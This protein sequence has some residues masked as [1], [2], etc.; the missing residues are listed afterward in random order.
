MFLSRSLGLVFEVI[1]NSR[2]HSFAL[3][4]H[5]SL[6]RLCSYRTDCA[7]SSACAHTVSLKAMRE[8]AGE[9]EWERRGGRSGSG[10]P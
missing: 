3:G 10:G 6:T 1:A 2:V 9:R 4:I 5:L 7:V 8:D